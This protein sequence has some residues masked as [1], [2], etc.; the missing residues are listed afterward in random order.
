MNDTQS[1]AVRFA[2]W[3]VSAAS[4]TI[5]TNKNND[6]TTKPAEMH[7]GPHVSDQFGR[8]LTA[9]PIESVPD[10]VRHAL[11]GLAN[12]FRHQEGRE[13]HYNLITVRVFL[14]DTTLHDHDCKFDTLQSTQTV[15]FSHTGSAKFECT[16]DTDPAKVD[17]KA[18]GA[19]SDRPRSFVQRAAG[20]FHRL[21]SG[22]LSMEQFAYEFVSMLKGCPMQCK[23]Q[24]IK[25]GSYLARSQFDPKHMGHMFKIS[26]EKTAPGPAHQPVFIQIVLRDIETQQQAES[27]EKHIG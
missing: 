4:G 5:K 14:P 3:L 15:W 25:Q 11:P 20:L 1:I 10:L 2:R 23:T 9:A 17:F 27:S 8:S 13:L 18:N 21:R 24:T 7:F 22:Q 12:K 16:L 6:G 19:I 26:P